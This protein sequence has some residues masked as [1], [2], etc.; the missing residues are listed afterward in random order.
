[1]KHE[2][3]VSEGTRPV[4]QRAYKIGPKQKEILENMVKDMID[5]YIIEE[6]CSPWGA[7]CMLVA[8]RNNNGYRFVVDFA[9]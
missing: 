5:Q 6:S 4:R 7:T 2:I 8:K 9:Y 3:E 1:L